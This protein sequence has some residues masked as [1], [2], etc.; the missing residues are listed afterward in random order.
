MS[1]DNSLTQLIASAGC[2]AFVKSAKIPLLADGD[3]TC[4]LRATRAEPTRGY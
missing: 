4:E 3:F 1:Q 2:T